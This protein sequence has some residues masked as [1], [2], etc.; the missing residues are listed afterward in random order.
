MFA[1]SGDFQS[2]L[3]AVQSERYLEAINLLEKFCQQCQNNSQT[4]CKEYIQ[5]QMGL[6]KAY[7]HTGEQAKAIA[8]CQQLAAIQNPQIQAW[9]QRVLPSLS[10]KSES[11]QTQ[12]APEKPTLTPEEAD[13]LLQAGHKALKFKR[14]ADAVQALEQYCQSTEPGTKDYWQAQMWLV[15]AYQGNEQLEQ[16]IALCQRLTTCEQ[17]V[18]QIWARRFISNLLPTAVTQIAVESTES[19]IQEQSQTIAISETTTK[20][21]FRLKSLHEFKSFC[22]Q[23]LLSDLK[24]IETTRKEVL[25]SIIFVSVAVFVT[26]G[27]LFKFFPIVLQTSFLILFC[28]LLVILGCFCVLVAFYTSATETYARGFKSIIIEKIFDFINTNYKLKYTSVSSDIE[29]DFTMSAFLHSQLFQGLLKPNKILQEDCICGDIGETNIFFSEIFAQVE[30][31]HGWARYLNFAQ[32]LQALNSF[33]PT[34]IT[35]RIFIFMLPIY[36]LVLLF[37]FIK[38]TPYVTSRIIKGQKIDY[39]RFKEEV[40]NNEFSRKTIFQGLFFRAKFNKSFPGK[41]VVLPKLNKANINTIS[42]GQGKVIKLEDP[43]FSKLYTVYGDNQV[44]ARY[45]LSTNLMEK[46]VKFRKKAGKN[47]YVSFVENMIYIA[48]ESSED[49]FEPKLYNSMLSFTPMREYFETIQLMLGIVDD[50]NLNRR[51]WKSE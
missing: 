34:W 22:Q 43:E 33:L 24:T 15:K 29:T 31:R 20:V 41:T 40:I 13:Q 4:N 9:V 8:L 30:V 25:R 50:L 14:Y 12:T 16:A 17:E 51:I 5:A 19:K 1:E 48:V 6:V 18:T 45:I 26:V 35:R 27:F 28:F 21:E 36:I 37:Q 49:L 47:I 32:Q 10:A 3:D 39:Q 11:T 7:H 2:G 38:G 46:L 42:I 44:E 23:T